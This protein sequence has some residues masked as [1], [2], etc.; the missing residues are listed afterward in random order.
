VK[1]Q[2]KLDATYVVRDG[3]DMRVDLY[4]GLR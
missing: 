1:W 4:A 3:D 2:R